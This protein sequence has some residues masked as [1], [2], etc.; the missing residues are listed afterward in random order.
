MSTYTCVD[1][2]KVFTQ[3]GRYTAHKARKTP[4]KKEEKSFGDFCEKFKE[5]SKEKTEEKSE[6]KSFG[7]F[8]EK[9]KEKSEEKSFGDF[10]EKSEEKSKKPFLKWVGGKTQIIADVLALF[11]QTMNNYHEPFLG[12]GSV[13]LALLSHRASG[14]ITMK[15]TVYASD[16]NA[17]LIGLYKT[18]QSDP[19]GLIAAVHGMMEEFANAV[20]GG[21][22][23]RKATTQEEALSSPES[24]YFWIRKQFNATDAS[25][26][27][28]KAAMFLFL[29]K[30][31]FRGVYREGP[32]G[33][34]V[35]YG[36]YKNPGIID[37][38]HIRAVSQLIQGVV[39]TVQPFQ[40]S[41]K[42]VHDGDFVYLD[43]PYAPIDE[44]SFVSYTA[45]GFDI[46]QHDVL[47]S[48]TKD[49]YKMGARFVMSN[50]AVPL[51]LDAFSSCAHCTIKKIS[52]RRAIHSKTPAAR[53]EE[54]LIFG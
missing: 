31:C 44:K 26:S 33:F 21:T 6:E 10:C 41:M 39:F 12:G 40:E 35:P 51:V 37:A 20:E 23:N 47:F 46:D 43:P 52:C 16:L 19:E 38:D 25:A 28:Q 50:A 7:D 5:K 14:A 54:V 48:M 32:R 36:N 2:E 49:L 9:S 24:Y 22:V 17:N 53:V 45:D 15:G 34:N 18:I 1:C 3:K 4:C 27:L 11:P 29:N 42:I 30:T 8:C 13:L